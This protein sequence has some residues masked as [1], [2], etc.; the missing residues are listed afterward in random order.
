VTG[1]VFDFGNVLYHFDYRRMAREL[2]GEA[3]FHLLDG[4]IGS[5]LQI[6]YESGRADLDD[7]LAG[8][9]RMGFPVSRQ[10]FLEA[11]LSVFDPVA[12]M[13][14]LV[15]T[16]AAHRPLGLLSNTCPEHARL[17]IETVPELRHIPTRVYSFEVGQMKPHPAIYL[18]AVSAMGL[19][20]EELAF[21]DDIPEL[22]AAAAAVGMT[23]IP[24]R[25]AKQL[26]RR[27]A[28]L[29][30]TEMEGWGATPT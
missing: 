16:L 22:A 1:V 30:F 3:G 29:G 6:A 13:A 15:R 25:G 28:A 11:F 23:G 14:D 5:P 12:G 20:A 27:L 7:V 4:F 10:R 19:P 17:F 24:F 8:F 21:T 2:A 26:A 18:A 9:A